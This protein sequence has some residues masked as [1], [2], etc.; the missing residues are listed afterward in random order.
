MPGMSLPPALDTTLKSVQMV[1]KYAAAMKTLMHD[2]MIFV[3]T[4][5]CVN[6]VWQLTLAADERIIYTNA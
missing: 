6:A 1:M 3:F 4:S 2:A 5:V